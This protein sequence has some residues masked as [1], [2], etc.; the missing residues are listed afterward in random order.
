MPFVARQNIAG[1]ATRRESGHTMRLLSTICLLLSAAAASA[2]IEIIVYPSLGNGNRTV[3]EGRVIAIESRSDESAEDGKRTNLR[4]NLK[5]L[6]N[7]EQ[8][9]V[10]VTVQVAHQR[11][12][13]VTD[14]EGYFQLSLGEL[15]IT[16]PGW[17]EVGATSG[18]TRGSGRLLLVAPDITHGVIS[19][20]DDT[21]VVSEVNSKQRL[22][23]N[24]LLRNFMQREAVPGAPQLYTRLANERP[25]AMFYLS[26]SPRQLQGSIQSFLD[27]NGFPPGVLITKK[28][29]NDSSSEPLHDQVA[30]K[31]EKLVDLFERLPHIRF[32]LIGDDGEHDPEIYDALRTRYP[33]RVEAI[34]IRR[35]HPDPNRVR[36]E[37]Q[38]DLDDLLRL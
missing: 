34:W 25:T 23:K 9:D 35:V 11:W 24:S 6:M 27:H 31:T 30:Y 29:T 1:D 4:R 36:L 13:V 15:E 12:P 18:E 26:A 22:L 32:T 5:M 8:A 7:S 17:H 21:V 33:D 19:D 16:T 20:F 14:A 28:V 3:I 37:N 2:S 10:P 38:G